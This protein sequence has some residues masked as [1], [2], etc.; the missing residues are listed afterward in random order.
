[1]GIM[2]YEMIS[3]KLPFGE[4]ADNPFTIYEEIIKNDIVFPKY[5]DSMTR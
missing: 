3:G 5:F 1:M 4:F 2:F